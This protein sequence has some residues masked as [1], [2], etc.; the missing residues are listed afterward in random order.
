MV[1]RTSARKDRS[2]KKI[3]RPDINQPVNTALTLS[4]EWHLRLFRCSRLSQFGP[5]ASVICYCTREKDH[6]D[7]ESL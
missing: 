4:N 1:I 2:P 7:P 6:S 3:A 5:E